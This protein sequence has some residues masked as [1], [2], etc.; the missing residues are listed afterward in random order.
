MTVSMDITYVYV[1]AA[2]SSRVGVEH[3]WAEVKMHLM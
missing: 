2:C 3:V 1:V